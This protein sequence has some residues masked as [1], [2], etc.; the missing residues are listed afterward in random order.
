MATADGLSDFEL[1]ALGSA[2]VVV[3]LRI[4]PDSE[5]RF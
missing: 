3:I 5:Q 1:V 4:D 2:S